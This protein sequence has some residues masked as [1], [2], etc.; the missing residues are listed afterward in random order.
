MFGELALGVL[1]LVAVCVVVRM[2]VLVAVR[3]GVLRAVR[4]LVVVVVV[5]LMWVGVVVVWNAGRGLTAAAAERVDECEEQH[6]EQGLHVGADPRPRR[7]DL[8]L[9]QR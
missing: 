8:Q 1:V 9:A 3:V 2:L 5:V 6:G 7:Q 4:V